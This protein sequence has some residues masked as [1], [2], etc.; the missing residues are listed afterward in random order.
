MDF[1]LTPE[2]EALRAEVCRFLTETLGAD[3]DTDPVPVPPGYLHHKE[4]ERKLGERGWLSLNWPPEYGGAGRPAFDQFLVE[5]EVGLHGGP[6]SDALGRVIAG[7]IILAFGSEEQKREFLPPM[8][9]GELAWC[10]G[11]TEPEAGSDLAAARTLARTDGD[12]YVVTGRKLYSSGAESADFCLLVARTDPEAPKHAG[13]SLLAVP[14]DAPGVTVRPL[15][16]L[17]DLHWFNEVTFDEVRVPRRYRIGPE[18]GGWQVLNSALG[19][20]RI[21]VYRCF[22]H[23]RLFRALLRWVREHDLGPRQALARQRLADLAIGFEVARLLLYRAVLMHDRGLDY[24][25]QAAMVKLF[26]SELAQ[27]LYDVAVSLLGPYGSL[28]EGSPWAPWQGAAAHGYLSAAQETIGAGTSEVQRNIIALRGLSL[29][30][31]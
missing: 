5:E 19:V 11:Y 10:L 25:P 9:R 26:N 16:N 8:A 28:R 30:R 14:M 3:H 13:I 24:R 15:Y 31:G 12:Y 18:H 4:F 17:L 21:T 6:A 7:P 22:L 1:R 23:W 20:E 29:P 2:Q 27:R